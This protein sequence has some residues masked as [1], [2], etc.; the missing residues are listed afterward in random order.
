MARMRRR[1]RSYRRAPLRKFVWARSLGILATGEGTPL[2]V[3]LLANFQSEY[4]A[5][6]LGSTVVRVRGYISPTA[7]GAGADSGGFGG[8]F[9]LIVGRDTDNYNAPEMATEQREHD[10]WL[11]YLP[12]AVQNPT[13]DGQ[14]VVTTNVQASPFAVDIKSSRKIEELGQTLQMWR[15]QLGPNDQDFIGWEWH[16]S[17]GLKLP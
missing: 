15:N 4:G 1:G 16:L 7:T 2:G 9:G 10:D 6:L 17:I 13:S 11:A 12:W 3:D 5:Q 8:L 14:K